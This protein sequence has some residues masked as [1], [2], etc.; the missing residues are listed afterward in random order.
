[1]DLS[2]NTQYLNLETLIRLKPPLHQMDFLINITK[3]EIAMVI[4]LSLKYNYPLLFEKAITT[5]IE[6]GMS[7]L[8]GELWIAV[9]AKDNQVL[10]TIIDNKMI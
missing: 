1:M 8:V 3:D 4:A 9:V 2:S 7:D 5:A 10:K 6:M